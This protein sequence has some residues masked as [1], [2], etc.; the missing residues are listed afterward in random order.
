MT[1]INK[2]IGGAGGTVKTEKFTATG[3]WTRPVGVDTVL[4]V[5]G[6]AG[7]GGGGSVG[8]D[9]TAIGSSAAS[10]GGGGAG[11]YIEGVAVDV[12][13]TAEGATIAVD[14]GEAGA[15]AVSDATPTP[16]TNGGDTE[17]GTLLTLLGGGGG[18]S[19]YYG[20]GWVFYRNQ[21]VCGSIGGYGVTSSN[22]KSTPGGGIIPIGA[23]AAHQAVDGSSLFHGLPPGEGAAIN[24]SAKH[25]S[26]GKGVFGWGGS[27]GE[28]Q[29][30]R[31]SH[32]PWGYGGEGGTIDD[33]PQDPGEDAHAS[34]YGCGGGGAVLVLDGTTNTYYNDGGDGSAGYL[35]ILWVE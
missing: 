23:S 28:T 18:G 1:D 9:T 29:S 7:G 3:T 32:L 19:V 13:G 4:I 8:K 5:R 31:V 14:I 30:G 33:S 22:Y 12:T 35:E 27:G 21:T 25:T 15:G 34:G 26:V 2:F 16:G 10:A 17:F 11:E 6:I 24:L 20:G